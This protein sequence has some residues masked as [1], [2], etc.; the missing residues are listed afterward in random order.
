MKW[1]VVVDLGYDG[2][3]IKAFTN[4][5]EA[6]ESYKNNSGVVLIEGEVIQSENLEYYI[7]E[8]K[9]KEQK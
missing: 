6:L 3:L 7:N 8:D 5:E 1:F 9:N 2:L 4:K